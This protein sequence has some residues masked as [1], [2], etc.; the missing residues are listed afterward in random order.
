MFLIAPKQIYNRTYQNGAE[1]YMLM[2][3]KVVAAQ[4]GI[5]FMSPYVDVSAD[6]VLLLKMVA[7]N[8]IHKK[9]DLNIEID[10]SYFYSIL[11]DEIADENFDPGATNTLFREFKE[12]LLIHN[13]EIQ[14]LN[15]YADTL[16]IS[17][18]SLND[19]CRNFAGTSAKQCLLDIKIAEAKRLLI[20]SLLNVSDIAYRLGFEDASYFARIFKKRTSLSPS[21]FLEKYR[22]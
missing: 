8:M 7:E 11:I 20:Y 6:H 10:L 2:F 16:H 15:Q 18:A 12:L 17:L 3:D 5:D 14:S 1:G 4:I 9:P 22:K 21:G 13:P 19:I